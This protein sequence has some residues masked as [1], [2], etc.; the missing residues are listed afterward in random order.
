VDR[1]LDGS[2]DHKRHQSHEKEQTMING[3]RFS[4]KALTCLK[5]AALLAIIIGM[6]LIVAV[7]AS[8]ADEMSDRLFQV[9]QTAPHLSP[10]PAK[11]EDENR[12]T[13]MDTSLQAVFLTTLAVDRG[14]TAEVSRHSRSQADT[15]VGWARSFIGPHPSTGQVNGYFAACAL[16]HTAIAVALPKP[17][18]TIWQSFWIGAEVNT[19]HNNVSVGIGVRF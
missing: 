18:R 13:T 1:E 8:H 5:Q 3:R 9:P 11:G 12:W 14:Q 17:Y 19:I 4:D 7:A 10:L 2:E 15:E 6:M 16:L